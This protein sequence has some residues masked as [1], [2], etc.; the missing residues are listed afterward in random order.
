MSL[1]KEKLKR[2]LDF[3]EKK[4][5][6]QMYGDK[7]YMFHINDVVGVA[8]RLGYDETIQI[9]CALHD[10]LEDT[11]ATQKENC[12]EFGAEIFNILWNVSDL[13]GFSREVRKKE[14]YPR[15]KSDWKATVVKICD[16]SSNI[17]YSLFSDNQKKFNM[18][19][20]EHDSFF[21]NVSNLEHP[22]DVIPAWIEFARWYGF[23]LNL[24]YK[25]FM[26]KMMTHPKISN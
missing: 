7:P 13:E 8:Q 4:H 18:Y 24:G 1:E 19:M 12:N 22:V 25:S 3:S 21:E 26:K 11:D 17:R 9:A 23:N 16:R 5:G 2:A 14:G 20:N 6:N 10:V 15:I